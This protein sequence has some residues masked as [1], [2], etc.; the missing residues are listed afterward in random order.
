MIYLLLK[1]NQIIKYDLFWVEKYLSIQPLDLFSLISPARV[2]A[3][4]DNES[5]INLAQSLSSNFLISRFSTLFI[6]Q[7][8][9][10]FYRHQKRDVFLFTYFFFIN[11][12]IVL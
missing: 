6:I 11:T 1:I 3:T 7:F 10:F 4:F 2:S 12:Q 8:Y 5:C 9:L